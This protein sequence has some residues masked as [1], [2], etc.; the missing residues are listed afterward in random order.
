MPIY[1]KTRIRNFFY[2][3]SLR[4]LS[5]AL[6]VCCPI[7]RD[8]T[9]GDR[10]KMKIF[11]KTLKGTHFEIQVKPE[12]TVCFSHRPSLFFSLLGFLRFSFPNF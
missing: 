7:N 5:S 4:L 8:C 6:R 2:V 3:F 10:G 11:V 9:D 12:D 1:K